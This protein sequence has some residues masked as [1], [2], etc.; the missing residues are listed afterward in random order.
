MKSNELK[1]E[2]AKQEIKAKT[3]MKV[4]GISSCAWFRKM[5]G[6]SEFKQTE[7]KKIKEYLNLSDSRIREIF[8]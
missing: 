5:N 7:I 6:K 4:C 3:M 2:M 1:A 8:F